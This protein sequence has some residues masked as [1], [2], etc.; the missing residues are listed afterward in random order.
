[1]ETSLTI[2]KSYDE[3]LAIRYKNFFENLGKSYYK[4]KLYL[5]Q[6]HNLDGKEDFHGNRDFY[7]LVKNSSRNMM[8]K[9]KNNQLSEMAL[10][11]SA[12]DSI[13]RNF[14]GIQFENDKKTSLEIFKGI[15]KEM[16][17]ICQV[18]KEYDVLK[19]VKENINDLNSRYLLVFSKSSISTFLLSS[20][21][22]DEKKEYSFYIGSQF[23]EDLNK[24]E[25]ALKV[26]NKIQVHMERGNILILKNLDSVYPSMYD[27]F[28]QNFTVLSNKS[29]A[30]LAVG[31]NTNTFAYVNKDFRCI[32]TADI[33]EI[34]NEE[35]PFLNRFEKHIMS[36]EYL[37]PNEL[38]KEAENIKS[39]LDKIVK[40]DDKKFKAIPYDLGI[41]LANN[42][43]EEIQ[44]LIYEANKKGLNKEEMIESVLSQFALTLPQDIIINMKIN[45]LLKNKD[46]YFKKILELYNKGDHANFANFLKTMNKYKNIIY[47]F[48]NNLDYIRNIDSINNELIGTISKENIKQIIIS[49]IKSENELE[50]EL[51]YFFNE[52]NYK[53]CLIKLMPYEG[54]LMNYLKYF[55]ENKEK[56]L[57]D[58]NNSKK[59]FI[60]IVYMTRVLKKDLKS[61]DKMSLKER[62]EIRKKIIEESLS[63]LSGYYQIF[64]DNLNGNENLKIETIMN[65]NQNE[66]F[67]ALVN[68]DEELCNNIF[69][70][71]SYMNYNIIAPYN[72]LN[73]DNYTQILIDFIYNNRRLRDLINECIFSKSLTK[74]EDIINKI[75]QDKN[76]F[77]GKVIEIISVI[78]KYLS[79]LYTSQLNLLYFKAE[80]E[81]FF[82][83]LL[84]NS[85]NQ[86]I[87]QSE[88][89]NIKGKEGEINTN[90]KMEDI[91]EDKTIIEKI[92]KSYLEDIAY[93][94]GLTRITEKQSSNKI[95]IIFG[96]KIPGIK[97]VFDKIIKSVNENII[98]N[99]RNNENNLRNFFEKEDERKKEIENYFNDLKISNNS[100]VNILNKEPRIIKILDIIK[101]NKEGNEN[102][103]NLIINDYLIFH[104]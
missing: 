42:S 6:K 4:Y 70:S 102:L 22:S 35:A 56:D 19:R 80:K 55:I 38:I 44:G 39:I 16:Y 29:Y 14:S 54:S 25:Y 78:K 69:T 75:F 104:Y 9:E 62:I 92:A 101:S 79:K 86:K 12:V 18:V 74:N 31:S 5:K 50:R 8:E 99:Y 94:D 100:L 49:S 15:F 66:L 23:E 71:I 88:V 68:P 17:P 13:E 43:L 87:W 82:S 84:S 83:S 73:K 36:F 24:E 30:R 7:H 1:M 76:S 32:V 77:D 97:A 65:M 64:I 93:N 60:F 95:D 81:Q 89:I 3:K 63:H 46:K 21:L 61:M 57:D 67:K 72:G 37:L 40:C 11:E 53:I 48:S 2:G 28:N 51:D 27:L 26:L 85:L 41:L 52:K 103:Y 20:I 91:F 10:I 59:V 45:G 47:T 98:K 33:E 34:N 96:L 58:K 90:T